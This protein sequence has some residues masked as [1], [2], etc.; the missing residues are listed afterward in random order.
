RGPDESAE[1]T[2][3]VL[4]FGSFKIRAHL[5]R[6]SLDGKV[7]EERNIEQGGEHNT[8]ANQASQA[9]GA[10]AIL[11]GAAGFDHREEK[12]PGDAA[13]NAEG[14]TEGGFRGPDGQ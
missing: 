6:F 5:H 8:R 13:E 1:N 9:V 11:A 10:D 2:P 12:S 7:D 14:H 3:K 4:F